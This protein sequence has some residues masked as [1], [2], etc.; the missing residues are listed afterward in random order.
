MSTPSEALRAKWLEALLP[1]VPEKGWTQAAARDAAEIAGLSE[2][3]Q[4][5]AAPMGIRDLLRAF[6]DRA[7]AETRET[8][9]AADLDPL[10]VHERV[11]FGVRTW[12]DALEPHR[13]AVSNAS[14]RGFMPWGT[15]DA[16]ARTWSVADTVWTGIGDTA[17]DYNRYSKR[18]LLAATIAPIILYWLR[19]PGPDDLDAF[20]MARLKGAMRL[21]QTGARV[22]KPLLDR[23]TARNP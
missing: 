11:A 12:L 5:L 3:E 2:G 10:K 16:A 19:E 13:K 18:G 22:F 17:D 21:G 9:A 15:A 8:L 7:E 4:A 23:F 6:F 1:I 20:I 14:M